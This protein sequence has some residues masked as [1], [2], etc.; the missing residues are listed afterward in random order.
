MK[1]P[2]SDILTSDDSGSGVVLKLKLF[3]LIIYVDLT[4]VKY[5]FVTDGNGGRMTNTHKQ[6]FDII[7]REY[8]SCL[9]YLSGLF[10]GPQ[11]SSQ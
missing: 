2:D 4:T 7:M 3:Y 8:D 11:K 1:G 5:L 10:N 9:S 6:L